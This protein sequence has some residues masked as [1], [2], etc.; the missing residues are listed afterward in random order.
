V[1][2]VANGSA[3]LM[4]ERH[5]SR[6]EEV[7]TSAGK[8]EEEGREEGGAKEGGEEDHQEEGSEEKEEVTLRTVRRIQRA[9]MLRPSSPFRIGWDGFD[10]NR[11]N[12]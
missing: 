1:V 9:S 11:P 6:T 2:I 5:L 3:F 12:R 10:F 7:E 8:E 4:V